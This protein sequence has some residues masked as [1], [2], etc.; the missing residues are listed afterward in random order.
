MRKA[1]KKSSR[2]AVDLHD[3]NLL[4]VNVRLSR[5]ETNVT[6]IDFRF[7]DDSARKEKVLSFR[8]CA[9]LRYIMDFDVLADNWFAQTKRFGDDADRKTITRFVQAQ[10]PHWNVRYMPPLPKDK[11][12]RK[13]LSSTSSYRLFK[14]T[15]FG[16]VAEILA[17]KVVLH[18][19]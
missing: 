4:S 13:K 19:S 7:R 16:G 12:I 8:G 18:S 1:K 3:D 9:N 15:F 5:T 17:K 11:P 6:Q 14:I 10:M 2:S